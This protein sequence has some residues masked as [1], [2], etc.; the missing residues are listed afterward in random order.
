M[1][2]GTRAPDEIN[3][4]VNLEYSHFVVGAYGVKVPLGWMVSIPLESERVCPYNFNKMALYLNAFHYGMR[5]PFNP[6]VKD[7][8]NYFF[9]ALSQ[10][11]PN[12]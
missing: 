5:L 11:T 2:F 12:N 7:V 9:I 3:S 4:L 10:I 6:F 8:F 1:G